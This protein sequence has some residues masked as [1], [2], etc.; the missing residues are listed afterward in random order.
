[1]KTSVD[2]VVNGN[3]G[4]AGAGGD[5]AKINTLGEGAGGYRGMIDVGAVDAKGDRRGKGCGGGATVSA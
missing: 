1:M 2:A 5:E 4:W 3:L